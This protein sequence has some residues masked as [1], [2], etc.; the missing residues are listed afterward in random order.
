MKDNTEDTLGESAGDHTGDMKDTEDTDKQ[1]DGPQLA[2]L[3]EQATN[4]RV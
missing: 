1:T 4:S 3:N 2:V